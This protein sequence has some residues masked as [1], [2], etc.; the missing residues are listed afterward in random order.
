MS[1]PIGF[2]SKYMV[3]IY[4]LSVCFYNYNFNSSI[5]LEKKN[6]ECSLLKNI[7]HFNEFIFFSEYS[8]LLN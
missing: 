6:I 7:L 5:I 3:L 1:I 2:V 4:F 8:V